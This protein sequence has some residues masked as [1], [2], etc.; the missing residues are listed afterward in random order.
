MRWFLLLL[1]V[2][3]AQDAAPEWSPNAEIT[4]EIVGEELHLN[5]PYANGASV[6]AARLKRDGLRVGVISFM[7]VEDHLEIRMKYSEGHSYAVV[8]W[9]A[10]EFGRTPYIRSVFPEV[11]Q[12]TS[13]E[14][15]E[16]TSRKILDQII[17]SAIR[18]EPYTNN[19]VARFHDMLYL[20]AL[21]KTEVPCIPCLE[22]LI[23]RIF[24]LGLSDRIACAQNFYDSGCDLLLE[25][26]LLAFKECA[27]F[28]FQIGKTIANSADTTN[29]SPRP[30]H[31]TTIAT[32]F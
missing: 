5:L 32:V 17:Q 4:W 29:P 1:V 3:V 24:E 21:T 12:C 2:G 14:S 31:L 26:P 23:P 18:M 20:A 25:E 10:N 28:E 15:N 9:N 13:E 16:L 27:G 7:F 8:Y 22:I 11:P 30:D 19:A 6:A